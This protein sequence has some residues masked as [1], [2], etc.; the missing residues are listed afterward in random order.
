MH[1]S[2]HGVALVTLIVCALGWGTA[3]ARA[4]T[5]DGLPT[6]S[7]NGRMAVKNPHMPQ[8]ASLLTWSPF[9]VAQH[10]HRH[11]VVRLAENRALLKA[12]LAPEG[13]RGR[14]RWSFGDGT[15]QSGSGAVAHRYA[16]TGN[17]RVVVAAYF[18][19]YKAWVPFDTVLLTVAS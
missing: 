18:A 13:L 17:Y 16:R 7:A 6:I 14:W 5:I 1:R 11:Q 8:N 4:C 15:T 9:I 3:S 2:L 19:A 12:V 10:F